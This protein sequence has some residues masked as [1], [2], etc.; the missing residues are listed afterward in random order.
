MIKVIVPNKGYNEK[1]F[2][3]HFRNGVGIFEDEEKGRKVARRMGYEIEEEEKKAPAKKA[4]KR[5]T[6][7]KKEDNKVE[8]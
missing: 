2:G 1:A 4:P 3:V 5:K 6:P 8:G 7:A